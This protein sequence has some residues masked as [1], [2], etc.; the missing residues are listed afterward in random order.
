MMN[1]I[2]VWVLMSV[3]WGS[4]DVVYYSPPVAT[5][6]DCQRL[7]AAQSEMYTRY[8]KSKCVQVRL[9]K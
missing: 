6:E 9:V 2:L 1:F 3:G 4:H 7:Q 5:L 8:M